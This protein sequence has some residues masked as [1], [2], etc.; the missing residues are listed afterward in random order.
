MRLVMFTM[1]NDMSSSAG[2][3]SFEQLY[4][5][6]L[7]RCG[8]QLTISS[9]YRMIGDFEYLQQRVALQVDVLHRHV[10]GVAEVVLAPRASELRLLRLHAR[11]LKVRTV[12]IDGIA[13]PFEQLNFLDEVVDENYRDGATFDLFYRGAIVASKEGE[14]IIE[15]PKHV[16]FLEDDETDEASSNISEQQATGAATDDDPVPEGSSTGHGH[17]LLFDAWDIDRLPKSSTGYKPIIVRIEYDIHEPTGGLRFML[18]DEE[19]QPKR[20][21]HM[22]TYCG[23]FGG[24]CDGARTWMPCRD[25]LRDACTFRIELTVPDWLVAACR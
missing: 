19:Y 10:T 25:T 13:A 16:S 7:Y 3:R 5:L 21:P 12:R 11:Q 9:L 15:I 17:T 6:L 8:P 22:Y 1:I 14:L 23:P 4:K 18:P 2:R 24:L 20:S